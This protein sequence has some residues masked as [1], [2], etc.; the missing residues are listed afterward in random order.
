M[1]KLMKLTALVMA[2]LLVLT[3]CA[4]K[5]NETADIAA[6]DDIVGGKI[7]VQ[8]DS[9]A[10][11]VVKADPI[12]DS[13]KDDLVEYKT[14]DEALMDLD[15]GRIDAVIIDKVAGMYKAAQKPDTYKFAE[16]DF[17][18]DL[19]VIGFRKED[20]TL[21]NKVQDALNKVV[22]SG[23]AEEISVKW[24]EENIVVEGNPVEIGEDDGSWAYIQGKGKLVVGLDATFAPMG[25][26]DEAGE[27]VGFDIDLAN[28]VAKELG[29]EVEFQPIDWDAKEL[30]LNGKKIDC[31]WNGMSAT[32]ERM[33]KMTLSDPYLNNTISIMSLK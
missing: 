30:E 21:R 29:V 14:Y 22:A 19:Y 27:I 20:V 24:F 17:G 25:F 6:K 23:E 31:I 28:A 32:P 11:E 15:I 12:Y 10:L 1:K 7:G 33:E 5:T 2:M 26:R 13:I 9:A 16:E 3:A 8:V 18:E 4:T